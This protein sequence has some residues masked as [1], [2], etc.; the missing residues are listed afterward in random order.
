[1]KSCNKYGPIS[2]AL[3]QS[4]MKIHLGGAFFLSAFEEKSESIVSAFMQM[5]S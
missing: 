1:M 3:L 5:A 2:C 4:S